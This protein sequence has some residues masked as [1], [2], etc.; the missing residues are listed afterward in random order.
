MAPALSE[1]FQ[2]SSPEATNALAAKIAPMLQP[3]DTLL[4]EGE[5][6]AGKTHFARALIQTRLRAAGI[7]EDVPSPTFTLVQTYTDTIAE[8]WHAD[9]YRLTD[10]QEVHELGLEDAFLTAICLVEWPEKLDDIRPENALTIRF[11]HGANDDTRRLAFEATS[12][13]WKKLAPVLQ[14]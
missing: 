11:D 14:T 9:L 12:D 2:S 6:G 7:T 8:I 3:G 4:L 13:R 1:E 10:V 5:I